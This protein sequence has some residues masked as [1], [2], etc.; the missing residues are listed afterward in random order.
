MGERKGTKVEELMMKLRERNVCSKGKQLFINIFERNQNKKKDM[1]PL[2][3]ENEVFE[4]LNPNKDVY[5]GFGTRVP[6]EEVL[7]EFLE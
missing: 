5:M 1:M 3:V 4:K 7:K 6:I 2:L